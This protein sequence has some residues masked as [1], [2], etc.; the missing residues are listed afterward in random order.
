MLVHPDAPR[1]V[2]RTVLVLLALLNLVAL[3]ARLWPWPAALHLGGS[4]S[5]AIAPVICLAAYVVLALWIG[6]ARAQ[7]DRRRLLQAATFGVAGGAMLIGMVGLASLQVPEGYSAHIPLQM[8]LAGIAV[9]L[10]G[11]AAARMT[12]AGRRV[13]FAVVGGLWSAMVSSLLACTALLAGTYAALTPDLAADP[14]G[15][16]QRKLIGPDS[17]QPLA[18]ALNAAT[19]FLIVGPIAGCVA[20]ALFGLVFRRRKPRS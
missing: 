13:G 15:P 9:L 16:L 10:W 2:F 1:P 4:S 19:A 6:S 7:A 20:G 14:W 11:I 12:R 3:G 18:H 8:I 5:T 17:T